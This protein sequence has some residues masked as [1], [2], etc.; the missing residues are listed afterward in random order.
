MAAWGK[1]ASSVTGIVGEEGVSETSV[2]GADGSIL[3][4]NIVG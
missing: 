2:K 3:G 4:D 1:G